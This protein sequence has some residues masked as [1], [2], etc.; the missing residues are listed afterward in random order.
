MAKLPLHVLLCRATLEFQVRVALVV[1]IQS[2]AWGVASRH[3]L[4]ALHGAP[5]NHRLVWLELFRLARFPF[6]DFVLLLLF[7]LHLLQAIFC[8]TVKSLAPQVTA[9]IT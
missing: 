3:F 8:T 4:V 5:P 7:I 2:G 9:N 1:R 6:S